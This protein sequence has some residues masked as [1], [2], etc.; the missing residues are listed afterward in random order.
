[1][2]SNGNDWNRN[3]EGS[4]RYEN[5]NRYS[6]SRESDYDNDDYGHERNYGGQSGGYGSS[7]YGRDRSYDR[8]NDYG[9]GRSRYAGEMNRGSGYSGDW[10]R[11]D[12]W[13]RGDEWNRRSDWDRNRGYSDYRGYEDRL[14]N[15]R[16]RGGERDWWSKT[17]DEV[18]SWFGD[19]DAERRRRMD[20]S[21]GEYRGKGPKGYT[22]SDERIKEDINDRLSDDPQVDASDISV[23][24]TGCEVTLTGNV[25]ER[26]Q[27]RRAEDLAE[28]VSGVKNVENRIKVNATSNTD[29]WSANTGLS[30][31]ASSGTERS[32]KSTNPASN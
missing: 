8:G 22:R 30:A 24:V 15:E 31:T 12:D 23:T 10:N 21:R 29:S 20:E 19:D 9:E 16:N 28:S 3:R 14:G 26:W 18:S 17:K 6:R 13:N 4:L 32:T 27:K 7:G 25:S 5:E 2:P 1:M 11:S